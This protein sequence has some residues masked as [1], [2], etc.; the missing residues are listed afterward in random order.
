[1]IRFLFGR[2]AS[3]IEWIIFFVVTISAGYP[4]RSCP[5]RTVRLRNQIPP[6]ISILRGDFIMQAA[7]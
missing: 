2:G 5:D 1:M 6:Q 7:C 3:G 4:F